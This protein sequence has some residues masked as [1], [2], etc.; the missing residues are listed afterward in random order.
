MLQV[1]VV[2]TLPFAPGEARVLSDGADQ[3]R[4]FTKSALMKAARTTS[5]LLVQRAAARR[6]RLRPAQRAGERCGGVP[7]AVSRCTPIRP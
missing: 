3:S 6:A 1:P 2:A 7:C 4:H 5:T